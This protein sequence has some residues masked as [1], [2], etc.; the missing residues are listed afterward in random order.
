VQLPFL[1]ETGTAQDRPAP[2]RHERNYCGGAA[3]RAGDS[4]FDARAHIP[5]FGFAVLAVLGFILEMFLAKEDLLPCAE[6]E[7]LPTI[8]AFQSFVSEFHGAHTSRIVDCG[9]QWSGAV[10]GYQVRNSGSRIRH[11]APA[12]GEEWRAYRARAKPHQPSSIKL[13]EI[14]HDASAEEAEAH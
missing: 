13:S 3:L 9:S 14:F 12:C 4:A 8:N 1:T 7:S 10:A 6:D 11:P 2:A 5:S